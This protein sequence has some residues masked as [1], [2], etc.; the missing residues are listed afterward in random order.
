MGSKFQVAMPSTQ[1]I[2]LAVQNTLL[3]DMGNEC[4]TTP[5]ASTR[6]VLKHCPHFRR[7]DTLG[8]FMWVRVARAT[9]KISLP[10]LR[11]KLPAVCAW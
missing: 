4:V 8:I 3:L 9:I 10:L 2:K 5:P 11:R 7:I 6:Q 1:H